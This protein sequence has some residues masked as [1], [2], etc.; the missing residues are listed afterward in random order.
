M[1]ISNMEFQ[2]QVKRLHSHWPE[3]KLTKDRIGLIF[4]T[5]KNFTGYEFKTIVDKFIGSKQD[6]PLP[7][8]FN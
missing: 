6:A 1:S 8:D 2:D 7:A 3:S 4:N 5:A